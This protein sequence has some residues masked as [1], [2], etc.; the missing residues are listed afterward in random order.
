MRF[1]QESGFTT[2]PGKYV[3]LQEWVKANQARFAA[4]YP[5][6]TNLIGIFTVTFTSEK[7]AG[8][9]QMLEQ[10]DSY[11]ALDR[12]AALHK[13][14]G[15]E[16]TRLY[17]EFFSFVDISP[18]AG[19]SQSLLKDIVDATIFDFAAEDEPSKEAVGTG[20]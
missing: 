13:D 7:Q 11:G 19:W 6:G 3:E 20:S 12:M 10:L 1:I 17:H 5:E 8:E 4:S 15:S 9:I 18:T 14:E 2:R 16:F